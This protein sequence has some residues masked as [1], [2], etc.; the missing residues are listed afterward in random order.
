MVLIELDGNKHFKTPVIV[1]ITTF[2]I[3]T[4]FMYGRASEEISYLI[5]I[6]DKLY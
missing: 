6:F 1:K 2:E 5:Q 3:S 4:Y